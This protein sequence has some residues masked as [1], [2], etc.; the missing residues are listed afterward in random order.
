NSRSFDEPFFSYDSFGKSASGLLPTDRP[1][2]FKGYT[3]YELNEG[4]RASTD[5]GLFS[6]AYSGSPQTSYLDVGYAFPGAFPTDIVGRGKWVDVS[7]DPSTGA[8]TMSKPRTFRT[9]WFLQSDLQVGQSYKISES[10][11]L[12]FSATFTNLFNRR[13]TT[14]YYS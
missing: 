7:Q 1:N 8:I 11:A 5:F 13:S 3:Y 14:A 9:P 4:H 10:K 2:A 12:R 6:Y